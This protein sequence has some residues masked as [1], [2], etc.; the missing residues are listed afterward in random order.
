[1]HEAGHEANLN[2]SFRAVF[3]SLDHAHWNDLH[4][5]NENTNPK[6]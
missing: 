5:D 2:S 4:T 3:D 1:M 6:D